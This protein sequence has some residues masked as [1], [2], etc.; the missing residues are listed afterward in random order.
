M[1]KVQADYLMWKNLSVEL[2]GSTTATALREAGADK[3]KIKRAREENYEREKV[4]TDALLNWAAKKSIVVQI[5]LETI[6]AALKRSKV[7]EKKITVLISELCEC[8]MRIPVVT[9]GETD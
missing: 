9:R 3:E 7:D 5:G 4:V 8:A 6:D 2:F 1:H